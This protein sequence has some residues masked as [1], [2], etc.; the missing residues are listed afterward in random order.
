MAEATPRRLR[1][2]RYMVQ[3]QVGMAGVSMVVSEGASEDE[4]VASEEVSGVTAVALVVTEVGM[5]EGSEAIEVGMEEEVELATKAVIV[6]ASAVDHL[7]AHLAGLEVAEEATTIKEMATVVV[8]MAEVVTVVRQAA[9][10][11]LL[12][13]VVETDMTTETG[14][15]VVGETMTTA[16]ESDI[17][18][19]TLTT[20]RD[21][22]A[23]TRDSR[24]RF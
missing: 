5:E 12:A 23:D 21:R 9:T 15:A 11:I 2:N 19:A 4:A 3:D 22:S 16:L 13:A 14:M 6:A 18:T 17:T 10:E 20:I 1:R 24:N 8:G 7:L